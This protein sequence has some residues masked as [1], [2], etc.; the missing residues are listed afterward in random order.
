[1]FLSPA[2]DSPVSFTHTRIPPRSPKPARWILL[3][4][5]FCLFQFNLSFGTPQM[6]D[7]VLECTASRPP[8]LLTPSHLDA[9]AF[10]GREEGEKKVV[11]K[12]FIV[13]NNLSAPWL[14]CLRAAFHGKERREA[15]S[16]CEPP[17]PSPNTPAFV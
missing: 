7:L 14:S 10:T 16:A 17:N 6:L 15:A 8:L 1:M 2:N 12:S 4:A 3:L 13:M 5:Y 9:E 11:I